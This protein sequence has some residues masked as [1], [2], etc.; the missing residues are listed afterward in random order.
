MQTTSPPERASAGTESREAPPASVRRLGCCGVTSRDRDPA[1][2]AAVMPEDATALATTIRDHDRITEVVVL[3]TCNR[4]EVYVSARRPA[5]RA[6]ALAAVRAALDVDWT[7]TLTGRAVVDHLCR[8]ACGLESEVLGEDH[9]LGQVKRTF[10]DAAAADRAGGVLSRAADAAVAVGQKAR[11]ETAINEGHVGYGSA[12]CAAIAERTADPDRL[13]VI[14]GGEVAHSVA[15]AAAHR[16]DPRIDVVNRSTVSNLLSADGHY[17]PLSDLRSA[18]AGADAVVTATGANRP[19]LTADDADVLDSHT[20]VVD[21]AT[22][23]DVADAVAAERPVTS[24]AAIQSRADGSRERRRT[25]VSSVEERIS[26]AVERFVERERESRAEDA[27]RALHGQAASIRGS[28][29]ER[30]L[31]RVESGDAAVDTVL[32]DLA[33]AITSR[34]LA[35]PTESLREAA[36]DGDDETVAAARRLFD[37]QEDEP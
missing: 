24:L 28:E 4:V 15:R 3:S 29:L 6:A 19:I 17:W 26:D 25:T 1:E 33:S 8:V 20:P 14:G 37:I 7:T 23:P 12:A 34:L 30:A 31:R 16:W 11:A 32:A 21:L 9:V 2:I 5:D 10:E 13:V 36:R 35:D 22:P 18:L 27:I